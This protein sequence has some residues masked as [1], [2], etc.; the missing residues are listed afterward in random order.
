MATEALPGAVSRSARWAALRVAARLAWAELRRPPPLALAAALALGLGSAALGA[1]G[2]LSARLSGALASGTAELMGGDVQVSATQDLRP[3][4]AGLPDG[5]APH[6][7]AIE[8]PTMAAAGERLTLV[9]LKAVDAGYPLYGALRVDGRTVRAPPAGQAWADPALRDKL[10]VA[11]GDVLELG[12]ARVTLAGLIE[13]E[14]DRLAGPFRLGPRVLI[15]LPD[16][17]ATGLVTPLSRV[18]T[19]LLYRAPRAADALARALKDAFGADAQVRT[20]REGIETTRGLLDQAEDFLRMA[21]ALGLLVALAAAASVDALVSRQAGA[22]AVLRALGT[23]RRVIVAAQGTVLV[24]LGLVAGLIGAAAGAG[25]AGLAAHGLRDLLPAHLS[26]AGP[27]PLALGAGCA[28]LLT[29][30]MGLPAVARLAVL[31]PATILRETAPPDAS[32]RATVRGIG[33]GALACAALLLALAGQPGATAA[34][35]AALGVLG[36]AVLAAGRGLAVL[37]ARPRAAP[38]AWRYASAAAAR[39][40]AHT[41]LAVA[42]L[43]LAVLA[44]LAPALVAGDLLAQWQQRVPPDAPNRFLIDVQ[45]DQRADAQ[46]ILAAHGARDVDLKPVVRARLTAR[47][48]APVQA[49]GAQG[50]RFAQRE[51]NLTSTPAPDPANR[52]VAGRWWDGVPARP[53]VSVEV[54]FAADLGIA[55][56]DTLRFEA[57]G[58]VVEARVTSLREVAWETLRSNFF[59]ILSPGALD[60]LPTTWVTSFRVDPARGAALERALTRAHPNLTVLDLDAIKRTLDDLVARLSAGAAAVSAAAALSGLAV[61]LAAVLAER[62]ALTREAALLRALGA[63]RRRIR[64]LHALRFALLGGLAGVLGSGAALLA[65]AAGCAYFLGVAY[66]PDP[67]LVAGSVVLAAALAGVVGAAGARG[68]LAAPPMATLRGR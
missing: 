57:A 42:A 23:P 20:A 15:G 68:V 37:L 13:Q 5:L 18:R 22:V 10:G 64:T 8:L 67:L 16:L 27:A 48:G 45:A 26:A 59:L 7:L 12:E 31:A 35:L 66:R 65:A 29:L 9:E 44:S 60:G 40:P 2:T 25:L 36:L 58:R 41:A 32:L 55:L 11:V 28:L 49:R 56:G 30:A 61:L 43:A 39:A 34:V 46:A 47:N 33:L 63:S 24:V 14:P 17:D 53:E 38:F 1:V 21:A 62:V 6:A 4:L 3:A 50:E 54:D 19:D 51:Q 52:I